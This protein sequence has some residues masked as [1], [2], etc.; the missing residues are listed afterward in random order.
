MSD[1]RRFAFHRLSVLAGGAAVLALVS[2]LVSCGGDDSA[3]A[4]DGGADAVA[5]QTVDGPRADS[6]N[7]AGTD[8]GSDAGM[9][10]SAIDSPAD[11]PGDAG[12]DAPVLGQFNLILAQTLC[13]RF[14]QCC[15]STPA[16]WDQTKCVTLFVDPRAGDLLGVPHAA[17][18]FDGGHIAYDPGLAS[19]CLANVAALPCGLVSTTLLNANKSLCL[20]AVAGTIDG[21]AVGCTVRRSS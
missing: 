20:S 1:L 21:G 7:D 10:D 18:S 19:Q 4:S 6:G 9:R 13:H 15:L 8:S 12:P 11:S 3:G 5:D 16:D 14:E 17:P 2:Q